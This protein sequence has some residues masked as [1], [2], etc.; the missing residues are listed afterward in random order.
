MKLKILTLFILFSTCSFSQE[1]LKI[2]LL[3]GEKVWSGIIKDGQKMPYS[4]GY[5]Y[6]FF[7][8]NQDNQI[9]PLLLGNKGL[10]VW[11]EEPFAFEIKEDRILISNVKGVV[12]S[13]H[14]ENTLAEA[15]KFAAANFFP[16]S[17]KMPDE[18]LFSKPQYNT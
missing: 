10:W 11:S 12:R 18:L 3:P 7:A 15:R 17:G 8:N 13:G 2:D 5:K 6:D 14:S 1:I 16:A 4:S 9:Q